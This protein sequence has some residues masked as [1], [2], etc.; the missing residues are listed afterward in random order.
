MTGPRFA[1]SKAGLC[2]G[3]ATSVLVAASVSA[4]PRVS[5]SASAS[6][7]LSS[8]FSCRYLLCTS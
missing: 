1:M 5:S 3:S 6:P 4:A 7:F 2:V 8:S